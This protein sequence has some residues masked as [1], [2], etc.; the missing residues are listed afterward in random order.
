M[1]NL[2]EI[3]E[4]VNQMSWS[5]THNRSGQVAMEHNGMRLCVRLRSVGIEQ[6]GSLHKADV[7]CCFFC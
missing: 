7:S 2:T 1:K 6:S 4:V 3:K 5:Y